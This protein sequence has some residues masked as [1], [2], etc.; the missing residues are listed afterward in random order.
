MCEWVQLAFFMSV[1]L[2]AIKSDCNEPIRFYDNKYCR[3]IRGSDPRNPCP[4]Q[5]DCSN[6][7]P[8]APGQC[9][10]AGGYYQ[11]NI[12]EEVDYSIAPSCGTSRCQCQRDLD[13]DC[14]GPDCDYL[15]LPDYDDCYYTYSLEQCC[16]TG[17]N[18]KSNSSNTFRCNVEGTYYHEGEIFIHQTQNCVNLVFVIAIGVG[19][20][21]NLYVIISP[22]RWNCGTV[23]K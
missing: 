10:Y 2:I 9:F 11:A 22:V 16:A 14:L 1:Q 3:P 23:R 7:N 21:M 19:S 18:C 15:P 20:T 5:F 12:H 8:N 6:I 17:Y 4:E 13:F